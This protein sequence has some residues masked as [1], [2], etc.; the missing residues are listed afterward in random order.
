MP[1]AASGVEKVRSKADSVMMKFFENC[2]YFGSFVDSYRAS[3]YVKGGSS[4]VKKNMLFR[5]APDFL[6][7]ERD[8]FFEA[9]V[10]KYY[11]AP[12]YFS[13]RITALSSPKANVDDVEERLMQFLEV[14]IYRPGVINDEIRLPEP[15]GGFRYYRFEY[16]GRAD[17]LGLTVHRIG[18]K[19]KMRSEHLVSGV[20]Y[21]VDGLW[22]VLR[23]DLRGR[24]EFAAF[25]VVADYSPFGDSF[26]LPESVEAF[27]DSGILG[28]RTESRYSA[29]FRYVDV[30]P[31]RPEWESGRSYDLSGYFVD[32]RDSV[33]ITGDDKFWSLERPVLLSDSEAALAETG[34]RRDSMR[35]KGGFW[36]ALNGVSRGIFT[37]RRFH[38]YDSQMFYSGLINP[39]ELSYS[40]TDGWIYRQ[41]FGYSRVFGNGHELLFNP[42]VGI[43]TGRREVYFGI[44]VRWV[45]QPRRFGE[46]SFNVE[47]RSQ[48]YDAKTAEMLND[49]LKR[50]SI[51][52]E[53][54]KIDYY[55]HLRM[56]AGVRFEPLNGLIVGTGVNMSR[57][58][59]VKKRGAGRILFDGGDDLDDLVNSEYRNFSVMLGVVWTPCQYYRIDGGIKRYAGSRLPTFTVEFTKGAR[60]LNS[61]SDFSKVEMDVHHQ[62]R[63]G[64][65]S[66]F[67]YFAGCGRFFTSGSAFFT[68]FDRF[69]KRIIPQSWGDP[70]GGVFNLLA[71]QWYDASQRYVQGHVMYE[72][73]CT[74]LRPF[75][76][77]T[78]DVVKERVFLSGLYTPALPGYVECGYGIGNFIG[79]VAVFVSFA[80]YGYDSAGVKF[81][82][83]LG[84]NRR[85]AGF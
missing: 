17:T 49:V 4:V 84:T 6:Y 45:F 3:V 43:V 35:V 25:R 74:L 82:F 52:F 48:T 55:H 11:R 37:P 71:G 80:G 42:A 47:N 64:L 72:Y 16:L 77:V 60:F 70:A 14:N 79:N 26:T 54:L 78:K 39:L 15:A 8:V 53:D 51:R 34:R 20:Y 41:Q 46:F 23:T 68:N 83:E 22:N 57:Y 7:M 69:R 18:V 50:D 61:N 13:G 9:L 59:P 32:G 75:R 81:A 12:R 2:D 5:F 62:V 1:H 38:Y 44:P 66:S 73:P 58:I 85:P 28:N 21:I 40:R 63:T 67:R 31:K 76:G 10:E 36:G 56:S 27:F 24:R 19:P 65:M 33:L 29:W 30:E